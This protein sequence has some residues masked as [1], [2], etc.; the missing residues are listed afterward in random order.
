MDFSKFRKGYF[1]GD[2]EYDS[3]IFLNR[4]VESGYLPRIKPR[5]IKAKGYGA[6]IRDRIFDRMKYRRRG[7][8]E[9][10]F[11][12]LTNRFGDSIPS[13]REKLQLQGFLLGSLAM[14]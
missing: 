2:A 1:Y 9:G 8:C 3:G 10:F 12:A 7:V 11:G 6:R 4:V 5:K 13:F 14:L